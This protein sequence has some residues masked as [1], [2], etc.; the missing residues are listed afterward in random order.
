MY[1]L[2]FFFRRRAGMSRLKSFLL[3]FFFLLTIAIA[4]RTEN[5]VI[6][7]VVRQGQNQAVKNLYIGQNYEF[8]VWVE[9]ASPVSSLRIAL[10]NWVSATKGFE[11]ATE[12]GAYFTWLNVGG[13]GPSGIG[14]GHACVSVIPGCRMYPPEHVWDYSATLRVWEYNMNEISPDTIGFGGTGNLNGLPAGPLQHMVSIHFR[15]NLPVVGQRSLHLDSAYISPFGGVTFYDR[16]GIKM[17]PAFSSESPWYIV[18]V[19]GDCNADGAVTISDAVYII[20]FVFKGGLAPKPSGAGDVNC[21]VD[22][23]IADAVHLINYVFRGGEG[24]CCF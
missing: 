12:P 14:T 22:V 20:N 5:R 4:A 1:G 24:P 15:P 9:N 11:S 18:A 21:D 2:P 7:D 10:R 3:I 13:Y 17:V 23:S 19:C 6:V 8:R 16:D